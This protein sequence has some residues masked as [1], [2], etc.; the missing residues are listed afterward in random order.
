MTGVTGSSFCI[1][2]SSSNMG[3]QYLSESDCFIKRP[4]V[5]EFS[6]DQGKYVNYTAVQLIPFQYI[7]FIG[8]FPKIDRYLQTFQ[9]LLHTCFFMPFTIAMCYKEELNVPVIIFQLIIFAVVPTCPYLPIGEYAYAMGSHFKLD[10]GNH[11]YFNHARA[12]CKQDGA[13]FPRF[14]NYLEQLLTVSLSG[15]A[16]T[17]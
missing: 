9:S 17:Y 15:N 16:F 5:C 1:V 10:F 12:S 4:F 11:K 7:W 2:F 6:C 3:Q 13:D 14:S 8:T